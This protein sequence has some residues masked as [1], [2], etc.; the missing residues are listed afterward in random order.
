MAFLPKAYRATAIFSVY[1][2]LSFL[3]LYPR[4]YY[5]PNYFSDFSHSSDNRSGLCDFGNGS[6]Y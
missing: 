2:N 1:K 6:I 3:I 4:Q 5:Q